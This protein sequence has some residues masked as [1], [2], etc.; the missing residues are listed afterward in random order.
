VRAAARARTRPEPDALAAV[1]P[2]QHPAQVPVRQRVRRHQRVGEREAHVA[3][4]R[5]AVL[6]RTNERVDVVDPAR[7]RCVRRLGSLRRGNDDDGHGEHAAQR[8]SL[9]RGACKR[10][11]QLA[12]DVRRRGT[13]EQC[14][15]RRTCVRRERGG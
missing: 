13:V 10:T 6:H 15:K 7:K 5:A 14:G 4:K 9:V 2:R 8:A 12:I 1:T 3:G 11:P